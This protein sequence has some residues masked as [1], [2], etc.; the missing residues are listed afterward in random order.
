MR[1]TRLNKFA[2]ISDHDLGANNAMS[3][4][5]EGIR[6]LTKEEIGSVAGGTSPTIT[7]TIAITT[8]YTF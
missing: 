6:D 2:S 7:I 1:D 3:V 8:I 4:N 5:K